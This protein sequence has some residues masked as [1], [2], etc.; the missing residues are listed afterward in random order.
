MLLAF[1]LVVYLT[2][3]ISRPASEWLAESFDLFGS[4]L[5]AVL[6]ER[7]VPS[8][9]TG[10]LVDGV[11]KGVGAAMGFLPQMALFFLFYTLI[12]DSG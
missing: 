9:L 1:G 7:G 10:M 12:Q 8:L 4:W 5:D 2:F 3:T 11:V 6:S